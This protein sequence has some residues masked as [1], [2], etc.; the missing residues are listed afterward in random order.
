MRP[1]PQVPRACGNDSR[2]QSIPSTD[3][4]WAQ[5]ACR[6]LWK[7]NFIPPWLVLQGMLHASYYCESCPAGRPP[8]HLQS[9]LGVPLVSP[10]YTATGITL[11]KAS[12]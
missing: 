3:P 12:A 1:W 8:T 9:T 2:R 11:I 5:R 7:L 10:R 6:A 4:S